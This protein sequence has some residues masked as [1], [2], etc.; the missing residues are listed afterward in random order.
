[1]NGHIFSH[2]I[3]PNNP[4]QDYNRTV[5]QELRTFSAQETTSLSL[6]TSL[7]EPDPT[8]PVAAEPKRPSKQELEDALTL[9]WTYQDKDMKEYRRSKK[10]NTSDGQTKIYKGILSRSQCTEQLKAKLQGLGL[11]RNVDGSPVHTPD[12]YATL[13]GPSWE[14]CG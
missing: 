13:L 1:M 10:K 4:W 3:S 9:C 2:A 6:F 5:H 14:T 8:P 12:E 11:A 7:F